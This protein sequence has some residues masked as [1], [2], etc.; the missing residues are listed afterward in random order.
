P[1]RGNHAFALLSGR[2]SGATLCRS[3]RPPFLIPLSH[4]LAFVGN[5][6]CSKNFSK[7]SSHRPLGCRTWCR[8]QR[9]GGDPP[10]STT[11]RLLSHTYSSTSYHQLRY[12]PHPSQTRSLTCR[13][14]PLP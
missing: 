9:H 3:G 14:F 10:S 2:R 11:F 8:N 1:F 12:R 5:G 4:P 13:T 7:N 6:D